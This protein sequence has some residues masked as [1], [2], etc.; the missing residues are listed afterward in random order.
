MADKTIGEL[1]L[2]PQV[3][4]DSL[5][6]VEQNRTA[7]KMTGAQ[8]KEFAKAGVKVYVDSAKASADAAAGSAK[9]SQDSANS[10][11]ASAAA[12]AK[13]E[14]E[15]K[16]H[17][18]KPPIIQNNH[19]WTWNATTQ[20]YEDTGELARGNLMYATFA[21]DPATGELWMYTDKEYTGP[22]FRLVDG[23][24]EVVLNYGN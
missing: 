20:K 5:L 24:L 8:F 17:S 4:D 12:A 7:M 21:I 6:A 9:A 10:S 14:S 11:A 22:T 23:D 3:L 15:A 2:A 19:W 1:P 16:Q 18:G 13:S